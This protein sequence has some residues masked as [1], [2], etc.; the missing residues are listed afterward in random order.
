MARSNVRWL[1]GS[2]IALAMALGVMEVT[3]AGDGAEKEVRDRFKE[4][5]AAIRSKDSAKVWLMVSTKTQ[6][7]AAKVAK[8]IQDK[9]AKANDAGK[10]KLEKAVG[11]PKDTLAKMAGQ[12]YFKTPAFIEKYG[13]LADAKTV[14]EKVVIKGDKA[15]VHYIEPDNDKVT[16][17]L[18]RQDKEWKAELK[19][20]SVD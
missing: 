5:Q 6:E 14:I 18:V 3:A 11:L 16:V 20:G 19:I 15:T 1:V 17:V 2:A 4:L 10:A 8:G 7:G 13:E 12:D 9:Y